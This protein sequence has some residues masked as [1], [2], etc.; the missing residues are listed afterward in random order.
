MKNSA[1]YPSDLQRKIRSLEGQNRNKRARIKK[2]EQELEGVKE[3]FGHI[4]DASADTMRELEQERNRAFDA[5]GWAREH[6]G[7]GNETS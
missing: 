2:L 5:L 1:N 3:R 4:I 6:E 7:T